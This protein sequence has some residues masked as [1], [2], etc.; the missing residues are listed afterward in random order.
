MPAVA[1]DR[2]LADVIDRLES[3]AYPLTKLTL[4]FARPGRKVVALVSFRRP[5]FPSTPTQDEATLECS[6][7]E[8]RLRCGAHTLSLNDAAHRLSIMK[9]HFAGIHSRLRRHLGRSGRRRTLRVALLKAGTFENWAEGPL[10]QLSR[11]VVGWCQEHEVGCLRVK[12]ASTGDLPWARLIGLIQY[13]AEEAGIRIMTS[14][15]QKVA[16]E[17]SNSP[18]QV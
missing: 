18:R 7:D 13:K 16:A 12:V 1:R 17:A 5:V 11:E 2:W 6:C 9:Q 10:H 14:D 15:S 3:R 8:L 4:S